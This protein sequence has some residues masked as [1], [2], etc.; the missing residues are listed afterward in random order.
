V[1]LF[2]YGLFNG[3]FTDQINIYQPMGCVPM[4]GLNG[5]LGGRW[6]LE[7]NESIHPK[8]FMHFMHTRHMNAVL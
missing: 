5:R 8:P 3:A 6:L 2:I 7:N 4:L 1:C